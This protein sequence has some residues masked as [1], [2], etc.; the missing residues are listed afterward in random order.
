ME[1]PPVEEPPTAYSP[2]SSGL[3]TLPVPWTVGV[4]FQT[5]T[6]VPGFF[7]L[8]YGGIEGYNFR[9]V[10]NTSRYVIISIIAFMICVILPLLFVYGHQRRN[11][12]LSYM[13]KNADFVGIGQYGSA[14]DGTLVGGPSIVTLRKDRNAEM[15]SLNEI[16][17]AA[18][19]GVSERLRRQAAAER[20]PPRR[21]LGLDKQGVAASC[22]ELT[23]RLD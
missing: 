21:P 15:L 12:P 2:P 23:S 20:W 4:A 16:S 1:E 13:L 17:A 6:S 10:M 8:L 5:G 19:C 18:S 11:Y 14:Q 7:A 22:G 3:L 9:D